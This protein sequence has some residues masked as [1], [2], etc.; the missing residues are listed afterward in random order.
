VADEIVLHLQENCSA[1]TIKGWRDQVFA[2]HISSV[3]EPTTITGLSTS[4]ENMT[5]T[6]SASA[7]DR[8]RFLRQCREAL[9]FLDGASLPAG[10]GIKLDFST[11]CAST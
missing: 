3:A 9:A 2:A 7:A 1:A 8:A 6:I 4:G 11:R 5:M 10:P